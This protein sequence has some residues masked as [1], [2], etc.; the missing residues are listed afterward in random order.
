MDEIFAG[1]TKVAAISEYVQKA[2]SSK[3]EMLIFSMAPANELVI[4]W[5]SNNSISI[6]INKK[7]SDPMLVSSKID[8]SKGC[9][10]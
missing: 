5:V 4:Y 1:S 10:H 6:H 3:K 7:S 8:E 2:K 9:P